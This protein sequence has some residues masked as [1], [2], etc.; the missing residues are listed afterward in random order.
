METSL[1]QSTFTFPPLGFAHVDQKIEEC[2]LIQIGP[3]EK[4][5]MCFYISQMGEFLTKSNTLMVGPT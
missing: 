5:K 1:F 3:N 4:V 2:V